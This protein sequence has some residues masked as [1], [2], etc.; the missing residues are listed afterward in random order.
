MLVCHNQFVG[1][2]VVVG[3]HLPD[4]VVKEQWLHTVDV[5]VDKVEQVDQE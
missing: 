4:M 5:V 3:L 2:V 1:Y